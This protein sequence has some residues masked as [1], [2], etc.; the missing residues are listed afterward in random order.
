MQR[1]PRNRGKYFLTGKNQ[2]FFKMKII[3]M[4]TNYTRKINVAGSDSFEIVLLQYSYIF[5]LTQ[6]LCYS[7]LNRLFSPSIHPPPRHN[8]SPNCLLKVSVHFYNS[9]RFN[10]EARPCRCISLCLFFFS[11]ARKRFF[12][13]FSFQPETT[14]RE[15][16]EEEEG[17]L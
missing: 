2:Y 12:F 11:W 9:S 7:V 3:V 4:N 5:D 13:S 14:Q 8:S 1:A 17:N 6:D 10:L 15:R 16:R